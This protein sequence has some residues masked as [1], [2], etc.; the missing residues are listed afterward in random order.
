MKHNLM[1]IWKNSLLPEQ[2]KKQS[3][4]VIEQQ[5]LN[6][7]FLQSSFSFK[8]PPTVKIV[9]DCHTFTEINTYN[10]LP[11]V[12][13]TEKER[14]NIEQAYDKIIPK[15]G[16]DGDQMLVTDV[17]YDEEKNTVYLEV[18]QAKYSLLRA[19]LTRA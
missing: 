13:L 12:E 8:K 6:D 17:V 1:Q 7:K 18:K 5:T 9:G 11:H 2:L 15:G 10:E 3:D 19:I 16:Y 4:Q 14:L